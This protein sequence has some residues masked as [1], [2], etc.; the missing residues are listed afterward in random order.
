MPQ[1]LFIMA[2]GVARMGW[3]RLLHDFANGENGEK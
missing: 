2:I 3:A 1:K